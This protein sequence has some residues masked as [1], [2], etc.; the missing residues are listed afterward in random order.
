MWLAAA[1]P[2]DV[3]QNEIHVANNNERRRQDGLALVL[4]DEAV[5]LELPHVQRLS[6]HLVKRVTETAIINTC[7][8]ANPYVVQLIYSAHRYATLNFCNIIEALCHQSIVRIIIN[9]QQLM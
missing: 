4:D 2:H 3:A 1:A 9:S 5:A 7:M 6:V 8:T